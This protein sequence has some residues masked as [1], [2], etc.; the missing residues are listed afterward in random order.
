[1]DF[2][3]IGRIKSMILVQGFKKG[4]DEFSSQLGFVIGSAMVNVDITLEAFDEIGYL[5]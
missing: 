3:N 2:A 1:M 4:V 5:F